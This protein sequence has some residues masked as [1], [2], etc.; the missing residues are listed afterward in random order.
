MEISIRQKCRYFFEHP[1]EWVTNPQ[2]YKRL[3][4]WVLI[5]ICMF[6][7][8]ITVA[9]YRV[10]SQFRVVYSL[11]KRQND[12]E[13]IKVINNADRYVYFAIY[14]FTKKDI[15]SALIQAKKRGL[16]VVGITDAGASLDSNK[17]IV[18]ELR[19]AGIVVET[20]KHPEGIMH[21]KTVV[22]D[23]AY[24]SGSYNWTASATNINDEI[25]EIGTNDGVRKQYLN[26]IKKVLIKNQ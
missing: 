4:V 22:T 25:L 24:A 19:E 15:A 10:S 1:K 13:I 7:I 18:E 14:F 6:G 23:K 9:N 17:N 5:F 16:E 2:N 26:I 11:D 3:I 8:S 12:Q 21:I 20:Q